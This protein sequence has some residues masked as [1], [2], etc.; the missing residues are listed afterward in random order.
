MKKKLLLL[1]VFCLA[2][3]MLTTGVMAD[4]ESQPLT[5]TCGQNIHWT[6]EPYYNGGYQLSIAWNTEEVTDGIITG[7]WDGLD[8][9]KVVYVSIE[10][11]GITAIG[12]NAFDGFTAITDLRLPYDLERIGEDAFSDC[13]SLKNILGGGNWN[14][15]RIGSG[16]DPLLAIKPQASTACGENV[17]WYTQRY[18]GVTTMYFELYAGAQTGEISEITW[19]ELANKDE[20]SMIEFDRRITGICDNAFQGF[21]SLTKLDFN[22]NYSETMTIGANAFG[23][24]TALSEVT[25]LRADSIVI[26]D[27][28]DPFS[29]LVESG[30]NVEVTSGTCGENLTWELTDE[31]VLKIT[32]TGEMTSAPWSGSAQ[33]ITAIELPDGLTSIYERAFQRCSLVKSIELPDTLTNIGDYAFLSCYGL[34]SIT[35]PDSLKTIGTCAF[36]GCVSL[37]AINVPGSV[38]SIPYSFCSSTSTNLAVVEV[39][40]NEGT[41]SIGDYAFARCYDLEVIRLPATLESIGENAFLYCHA[42]SVVDYNGD[43]DD[44]EKIDVK[45]GNDALLNVMPFGKI[46]SIEYNIDKETGAMTI[47]G[48]GAIDTVPWSGYTSNITSVSISNGV[49]SI[50]FK[51]F[52]GATNLKTINIPD[53]VTSLG[54]QA[55]VGCTSL[56]SITFSKRLSAIWDSTFQNCSSLKTITLPDA[57]TSIGA[58]AF[59]GCTSL[60][61]VTTG[62]FINTVGASAFDNCPRLTLHVY[63]GSYMQAYAEAYDLDYEIIPGTEQEMTGIENITSSTGVNP[64]TGEVCTVITITLSDGRTQKFYLDNEVNSIEDITSR[65][66]FDPDGK[67]CTVVT[68]TM[69]NGDVERFYVYDGKD[70]EDGETVVTPIFS[71][72]PATA[73]YADAV[74]WAVANGITT[75]TDEN[76]FSPNASCTRAQV[77]TFLWR[78]MGSPE[79]RSAGTFTDVDASSYYAKAVRWALENGITSGTSATTFDPNGVCTR[80]Q[81]VTF[82][83][84]ALDGRSY[85]SAGFADVAASSYYADAVAWAVANGITDGTGA[86]TFSPDTQCNRAQIV[87]FLYRA[88]A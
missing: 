39:T 36:S 55:F 75:G 38:E 32:G 34:E 67:P 40:L 35:L 81:V 3:V 28:N 49:S 17:Y 74:A 51:A 1:L 46:G 37:A 85:G 58:N 83:M 79:P 22:N 10:G 71:D 24:C 59:D 72:V 63:D 30:G 42:L 12:D 87:T 48:S 19:S 52:A 13:S 62:D 9:S 65:P 44:W 29:N 25:G 11:Y 2:A 15:V 6:A 53:S 70:G 47:E 4:S 82:L 14:A 18:N 76:T 68:I 8:V 16:N 77:V 84:R 88:V 66:G 86:T 61:S 80:A 31:G 56:E 33:R 5:G 78:A 45:D 20:I 23:D 26:G 7:G 60:T 50:P 21:T 41:K 73:Y 27:G 43:K 69:T 57:V 64:E 54:A